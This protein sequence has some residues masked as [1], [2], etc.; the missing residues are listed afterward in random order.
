MILSRAQQ[1]EHRAYLL[2]L[3]ERAGVHVPDIVAAGTAGDL[4]HALLVTDDEGGQ[5]LSELDDHS[6]TD[7]TLDDAWRNLSK[8][9][10]AHLAHGN[11]HLGTVVLRDDGTTLIDDFSRASSSAPAERTALDGAE[12]LAGTAAIVGTPRAVDAMAKALEHEEIERI[13]PLLQ[14]TAMSRQVRHS[15]PKAKSLLAQLRTAAA[16][17][18]DV[19]EPELTELHRIS[20]TNLAMAVG[21]AFGVYLLLGELAGVA[22]VG[23]VFTNPNWWWVA[24]TFVVS[25]TPQVAQAV[26][27][28]GSVSSALPLG[29]SIGV[30]FANQFMGL[31]GG[32]VATTALVIRFFQK[33]GLAVSVAVSSGV[34]NTIAAMV[35]EA[36]LLTIG[37]IAFGQDFTFSRISSGEGGSATTVVIVIVIAVAVIVGALVFL[38]RLRKRIGAKLKPQFVS[39]RDNLRDLRGNPTKI[40]Q[41]FGGNVVSQLLFALTLQCAL[42]VYGASLPD[43]GARGDQHLRLTHRR[44]RPGAGRYGRDRSRAHRRLH[45]RGHPREHGHRRH[46][47]RPPLHG[48]LTADLGLVLDA[49]AAPPRLPLAPPKLAL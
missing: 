48:L 29:P 32:T 38:P 25:Q 7:A 16:Q 41:L 23:D 34:L 10:T 39:A 49:V 3:A 1:V 30:Q 14:A 37:L 21:A 27:M 12:L 11:L 17:K 46:V 19:P 13:L 6:L 40:I 9:H 5:P 20:P 45:R 22:S 33:R 35:A 8:L 2:L 24:A 44:C 42:H 15:L 47:H 31:V 36:I 28:L 26:G 43:H 4:G 18:I